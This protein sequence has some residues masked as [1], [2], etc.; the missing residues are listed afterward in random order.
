MP[1][2]VMISVQSL[3]DL[4]E[5][6][7]QGR[8]AAQGAPFMAR[9]AT[10]SRL[11]TALDEAQDDILEANTLDL[12]ASLEMAVPELV[13]DW[14]RL[15]PDRLHTATATLR[16]LA[17]LDIPAPL[18]GGWGMAGTPYGL[19]RVAQRQ[20]VPLGVIALVYEAL[21]ELAVIAAGLCLHTGNSLLLKGG[22]EA[23][24]TNLT[25][26][27][28]FH[29]VLAESSLHPG[30]IQAISAREGES[31]RRWLMQS[32]DLDLLIPYG[33]PSLVQQVC[34]EAQAPVLAPALGNCYLY[35]SVSG[36]VK[37]VATMVIESHRG[38]PDPVNCVEKVLIDD[39]VP[40]VAIAELQ[41]LLQTTLTV[42]VLEPGTTPTTMGDESWKHTSLQRTVWLCRVPDMST[43]IAWINRYSS[44]HADSIAT[45]SYEDSYQFA[46]GL[47]SATVYINESP[48]FIRNPAQSGAI[49]LG[50]AAQHGPYRGRITREAFL[51]PKS[52]IQ[53]LSSRL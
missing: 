16:R 53:G 43:A 27:T 4:A 40:Q 1:D 32:P 10:L 15:T 18:L 28:V 49:A 24:Q 7:R 2:D 6:V 3:A 13:L 26:A 37:T 25:I 48:R 8:W 36:Q 47:R 52:V 45:E 46:Q 50:M 22:N 17:A 35:W 44:G 11:A 29:T 30:L 5:V 31:A 20:W 34:R 42:K 33:R 21:P 23:S 39:Q 38:S 12:E 9:Q 14:L 41:H 19:D 51:A